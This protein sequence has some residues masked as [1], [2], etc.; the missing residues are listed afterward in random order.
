[1]EF[2]ADATLREIA[3]SHKT[4]PVPRADEIRSRNSLRVIWVLLVLA[5]LFFALI[6]IRLLDVPL[7]RDEGEYAYA[8]QLILQGVPPYQAAYN[9]KLPGTYAMYALILATFGQTTAGIHLG[10]TIVN[11]ATILLMFLLGKK[12]FGPWIGLAVGVSYGLLSIN[13]NILG[14]AAHANHFVVFFAIAGMLLL[15]HTNDSS[16]WTRF[17]G[18]GLLFGLAF[19]MKQHGV[20][21]GLWGAFW[22]VWQEFKAGERNW[23]RGGRRLFIFFAGG[24][25]PFAIACVVLQMAGVFDRFWFWT[26][27]YAR[28]Y[29]TNE[30]L[31]HV[32]RNFRQEF[33]GVI[34]ANY[35][36]WPLAGLGLLLILLEK[37]TRAHAAFLLGLL[38]CS[39][40]AISAGF[41]FRQQYFIL[42]LPALAL[43]IGAAAVAGREFILRMK[44]PLLAVV[45]P[46][47]I[48]ASTLLADVFSHRAIFFQMTPT[49]ASRQM[50]SIN[51]FVETEVMANYLKSN[52]PPQATIAVLGS[53][54]Q[55]YFTAQRRSATGYIYTYALMENHPHALTMQQEMIREIES[56]RPD[57][58][59][60]VGMQ[61]SW[62]IRPTSEKL[63]FK[64]FDEFSARNYQV[65]GVLD[66]TPDDEPELRWGPEAVGYK[67]RSSNYIYIFKRNESAVIPLP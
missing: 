9:M 14:M 23:K 10:L 39:V 18:S 22:L 65:F 26:F 51:P 19:L 54:P 24:M 57:F 35:I 42:L 44:R 8:G 45:V 46:G 7:E 15:F 32:W 34:A 17:F 36:L 28:D 67:P 62:L 66:Y 40:L 56:A 20:F 11:A 47:G 6:R 16:R 21:F 12:L 48:V 5:I 2:A 43:L 49:E 55:I 13:P 1:M 41:Y 58:L 64:W 60:M 31:A 25:V 4:K 37:K 27:T 63:I 29:A 50:Y 52:S 3:V 59:V 61:F 33:Q 38:L 30:P 53:E